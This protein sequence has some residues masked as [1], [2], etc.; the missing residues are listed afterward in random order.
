MFQIHAQR[1]GNWEWLALD[2]PCETTGPEWLLN[3]YGKTTLTI[4]VTHN[5][6]ARDRHPVF[7][8]WSTLIHIETGSERIWTGIV[9]N[10]DIADGLLQIEC[11]EW[12]GWLDGLLC[13]QK[14][15]Y[16]DTDPAVIAADLIAHAQSFDNAKLGITVTGTTTTRIGSTSEQ[17]YKNTQAA[18]TAASGNR[19][20][21][22]KARIAAG[23]L[24]NDAKKEQEQ[25]VKQAE[26]TLNQLLKNTQKPTPT[27]LTQIA[28]A[29]AALAAA[30]QAM[31]A[32]LSPLKAAYDVAEAAEFNAGGDKEKL[33]ALVEKYRAQMQFDGGMY[34]ILPED[35]PNIFDELG[36]LTQWIEFRTATT[37]STGKP[38]LTLEIAAT[39]GTTRN[40]LRFEQ[41]VNVLNLLNPS[42]DGNEYATEITA[43]GAGEGETGLRATAAIASNGLRRTKV[44]AAKK[45][46]TTG[47]LLSRARKEL[48]NHQTGFQLTQIT[49]QDH[50]NAPIGSWSLGDNILIEGNVPFL[51]EY[52]AW[53]R[54]TAWQRHDEHRATI[55]L[56]QVQ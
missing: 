22:T 48:K 7:E 29:K 41:G 27:Q 17:N 51:G 31:A 54:I 56:G 20:E 34:K 32:R 53:H 1:Y 10:L 24:H 47:S 43:I 33:Q 11:I 39:H 45:L 37:R 26:Q 25:L 21:L 6:K 18:Y 15:E 40:D 8:R 4:P 30:K 49:V 3:G 44:I 23:T 13:T 36:E 12:L 16:V 9:H 35:L 46:K 55:T 28:D 5:L 50:P 42:L 19:A 52:K 14:L 2:I 38:K